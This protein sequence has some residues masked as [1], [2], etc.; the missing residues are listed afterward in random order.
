[1]RFTASEA[2]RTAYPGALIGVLAMNDAAN[3]AH[4][5]GLEARKTE[6]EER[7]RRQHG[8][9]SKSELR[10]HPTLQAYAAYYK[11]FDKTYHVQLQLES[12]VFKGKAIP[13]VASLVEAM[14]MAELED[15]L[16]TAGHDLDELQ[17]D[18]GVEVASGAE[19]Y[20]MMNAR[21]QKLKPKDMFIHDEAGVLSSIL[22]GPA[23]RARITPTTRRVLFTAYA[24]PGI[25]D[26]RLKDHLERLKE[27]V[28]I[29]SPQARAEYEEVIR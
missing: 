18:P 4:H 5:P 29:V 6:L 28:R 2:W 19:E 16:L 12:V 20:V 15:L 17:G 1:M 8:T 25:D 24:P 7:L 14:F 9:A 23:G 22:Y 11:S 10:S 13:S 27:Y 26:Q 3:P 21:P